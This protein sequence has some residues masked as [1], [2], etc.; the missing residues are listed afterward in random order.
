MDL[1]KIIRKIEKELSDA[2]WRDDKPE[3]NRLR[4]RLEMLQYKWKIGERVEL[5]F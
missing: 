3:A 1:A 5:D 2:E 4:K